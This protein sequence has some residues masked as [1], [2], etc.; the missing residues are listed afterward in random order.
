MLFNLHYWQISIF[1]NKLVNI[2]FCNLLFQPATV[3]LSAL[4]NALYETDMVAIVRR[5]YAANSPVKIGCLRPH[6]KAKYEVQLQN[7]HG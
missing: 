1:S 6:I 7:V 5:V 4:I 3:A 2:A